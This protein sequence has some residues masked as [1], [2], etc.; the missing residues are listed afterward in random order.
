MNERFQSGLIAAIDK[1]VKYWNN[2]RVYGNFFVLFERP[3]GTIVVSNDCKKVYL[4]LG[5]ANSLAKPI[6]RNGGTVIKK[7]NLH[8]PNVAMVVCLTLLNW[9]G[10]ICY[11]GLIAASHEKPSIKLIKK[12]IKAYINAVD[13]GKLIT[14]ISKTPVPSTD[15]SNTKPAA[16]PSVEML[17]KLKP[18]LANIKAMSEVRGNGPPTMWVFRRHGYTPRENPN[19]IISIIS[20][21]GGQIGTE[22]RAKA[23]IPDLADYIELLTLGCRLVVA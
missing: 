12:A 17:E 22:F 2:D 19:N 15:T 1:D 3:D 18:A 8:S 11:D 13:K 4:V 23:L 20:S 10:K 16:P 5:L 14:S 7:Y 6:L 21:G 9:E